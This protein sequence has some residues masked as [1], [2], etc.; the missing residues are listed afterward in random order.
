VGA[1][2]FGVIQDRIGN[3]RTYRL[4]LVV[5]VIAVV[6][7]HQTTSLSAASGLSA[8]HVYLG[9][10]SIAGL[11]LGATQ[12][13]GRTVVAVLSPASKTAEMFGFWGMVGKLAAALG[14]V[15]LGA[16]QTAFGLA[17][18][19]LLCAVLF[20]AAFFLA[21]RVDERR[22]MAAAQEPVSS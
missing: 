4:T 12:S 9:V 19:I 13:A 22:G 16:L 7:I 17:N 11:C 14:L 2:V 15:A 6:G 8:E 18:A 1:L 3:M 5:W 10:G 21:G 20:A